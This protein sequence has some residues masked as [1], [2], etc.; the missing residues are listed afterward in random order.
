MIQNIT[1]NEKR[2]LYFLTETRLRTALTEMYNAILIGK[3]ATLIRKENPWEIDPTEFGGAPLMKKNM[4]SF[5]C[6]IDNVRQFTKSDKVFREQLLTPVRI[7][8]QLIE[9]Y[10]KLDR[11]TADLCGWVFSKSKG[12]HDYVTGA[13]RVTLSIVVPEIQTVMT[14]RVDEEFAKNARGFVTFGASQPIPIVNRIHQQRP[15]NIAIE[16]DVHLAEFDFLF[17]GFS[18]IEN[19]GKS[20]EMENYCE[21]SSAQSERRQ[22]LGFPFVSSARILSVYGPSIDLAKTYGKPEVIQMQISHHFYNNTNLTNLEELIGKTVRIFGIQWYAARSKTDAVLED[23]EI[24][25]IEPEEDVEMLKMEDIIGMIRIRG[26]MHTLEAERIAGKALTHP[27]ISKDDSFVYFKYRFSNSSPISLKYCSAIS[28]IRELRQEI[29]MNDFQVTVEHVIDE[30]KMNVEGL[31]SLIRRCGILYDIMIDCLLQ[32]DMTGL[33]DF[34]KMTTRLSHPANIIKK[35]ITFMRYLGIVEKEDNSKYDLTKAGREIALKCMRSNFEK[36][37][38]SGKNIV[39]IID[40]HEEGIPSSIMLNCMR[41]GVFEGF[42]PL[43]VKGRKTEVLWH[44]GTRYIEDEKETVSSYVTLRNSIMDVMRSVSHPLTDMAIAEKISAGGHH[45]GC[46]ITHIIMEEEMKAGRVKASGESWEYPLAER[47]RHLFATNASSL[48]SED[49]IIEKIGVG[50]IMSNEIC[51]IL[52]DFLERSIVTKIGDKWTSNVDVEKKHEELEH[53]RIR[54]TILALIDKR[55]V[56]LERV[57]GRTDGL[58]ARRN[59]SKNWTERR[60]AIKKQIDKLAFDGAIEISG[61]MVS[62]T[63]NP[64]VDF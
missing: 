11:R 37:M 33:A 62:K 61:Q 50:T 10:R 13:R 34:T 36:N 19:L 42:L 9:D 35:K 38:L 45:V 43:D 20:I 54:E 4:G 27:S 21:I 47:I 16:R 64:D 56:S 14:V 23:P 26:Q 17:T 31:A 12:Y 8:A 15:S 41:K 40:S 25:F 30:K 18:D 1:G 63:V 2:C 24:L 32:I 49:E 29:K 44:R 51:K 53:K 52:Q 6:W 3:N 55:P 39:S 5:C 46:F 48:F 59:I 60:N 57:Y 7:A 28:A 22:H 58:L